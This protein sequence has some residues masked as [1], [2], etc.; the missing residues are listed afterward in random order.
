MAAV[1]YGFPAS[2]MTIIAVTG[3][4]GKTTTCNMIAGL[5]GFAGHKTGMMTSINFQVGERRWS[6]CLKQSTLP[7]FMMQRLLKEMKT[8]GCTHV[9]VEVTSHAVTQHRVFGLSPDIA[10]LTCID[11]DHIEYHGSHK[12]YRDEKLKLFKMLSAGRRKPGVKKV[13]ILNQDDPYYEEFKDVPCDVTNTYGLKRGTYV[14]TDLE[15]H[16]TRTEFLLSIPNDKERIVTKFVGKLNVYNALAAVGVGLACGMNLR[17]I[18]EALGKA[19]T[20]PGRQELVSAGQEFAVVVDYAHTVDSLR[21]VCGI[22]KPLTKGRF[23][24]VF[25]CTGGG[26]DKAKRPLM[27]KVADECADMIVVTD[28]DPYEEN[29]IGILK[30]IAIGIKR[31]EGSGHGE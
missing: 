31:K 4:K 12:A 7:P 3:T 23:I 27:G 17:S 18:K 24:L 15:L 8:E 10:V 16:P 22:F 26:R 5:L 25:G 13:A 2:S 28:D 21:Q 11:E 29:R 1:W 30:E 9:V 20:V 14:A 19:P 6:N